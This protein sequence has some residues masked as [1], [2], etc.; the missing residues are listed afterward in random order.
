MALNYL[1]AKRAVSATAATARGLW[2]TRTRVNTEVVTAYINIYIY[3][4][5]RDITAE[6]AEEEESRDTP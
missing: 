4:Y 6:A 3:T 1:A 5:I 2:V